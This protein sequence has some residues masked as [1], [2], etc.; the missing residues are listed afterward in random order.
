MGSWPVL[1]SRVAGFHRISK[2]VE[3][4]GGGLPRKETLP[5][6]TALCNAF[7]WGWGTCVVQNRRA[8]CNPSATSLRRYP[9]EEGGVGVELAVWPAYGQKRPGMSIHPWPSV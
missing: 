2:R 5:V 7:R 3:H 6:F 1:G 8:P 9:E 4:G